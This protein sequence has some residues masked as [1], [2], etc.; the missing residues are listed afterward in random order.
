MERS[1]SDWRSA[2]YGFE[3][4]CRRL[5][6]QRRMMRSLVA[7]LIC[8]FAL[9]ARAADLK[10]FGCLTSGKVLRPGIVDPEFETVYAEH[11]KNA[12]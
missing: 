6:K 8:C 12:N 7:L 3:C 5:P 4:K 11:I 10:D 1:S 9:T 2:E